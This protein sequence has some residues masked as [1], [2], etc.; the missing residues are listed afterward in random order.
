ME[1]PA[2]WLADLYPLASVDRLKEL[3]A[4]R[5]G[6]L[7]R[8]LGYFLAE[9]IGSILL[10]MAF[11]IVGGISRWLVTILRIAGGAALIVGVIAVGMWLFR[12][13]HDAWE[14]TPP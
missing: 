4:G 13:R 10:W 12:K 11:A 2:G 5:R 1:T 3:E 9:R 8:W 6:G 14:L 7:G